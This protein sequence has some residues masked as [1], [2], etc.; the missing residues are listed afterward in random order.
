MPRSDVTEKSK[1]VLSY[2]ERRARSKVCLPKLR[3]LHV[4][5]KC[6]RKPNLSHST[7]NEKKVTLHQTLS[8]LTRR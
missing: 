3:L 1:F 2:R 4:S 6:R 8:K 5:C 7:E